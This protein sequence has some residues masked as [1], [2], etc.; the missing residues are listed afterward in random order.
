MYDFGQISMK[1]SVEDDVEQFVR[2]MNNP[3]VSAVLGCAM[4]LYFE[5]PPD[6]IALLANKLKPGTKVHCDS[7][8]LFGPDEM[9]QFPQLYFQQHSAP[10]LAFPLPHQLAK[11]TDPAAVVRYFAADPTRVLLVQDEGGSKAEQDHVVEICRR[12]CP[13]ARIRRAY[14]RNTDR[15]WVGRLYF[16]FWDRLQRDHDQVEQWLTTELVAV[17]QLSSSLAWDGDHA[18]MSRVVRMLFHTG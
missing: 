4:D 1:V 12:W 13:H 3:D 9:F 8:E 2:H 17:A 16:L 14:K 18:V 5:E 11:A 7:L 10:D 15:L 6:S